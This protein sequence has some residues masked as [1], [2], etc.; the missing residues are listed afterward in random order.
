MGRG[1]PES[2]VGGSGVKGGGATEQTLVWG[3]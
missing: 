1:V 3:L 2:Q